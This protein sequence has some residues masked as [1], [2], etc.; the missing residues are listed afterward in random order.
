MSLRVREW[1]NLLFQKK[2]FGK[3]ADFFRWMF[4]NGE[5]DIFFEKKYFSTKFPADT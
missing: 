5:K 1:W 2:D 3:A 4:E